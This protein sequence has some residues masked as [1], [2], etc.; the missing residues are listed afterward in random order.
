MRIILLTLL[1]A[2]CAFGQADYSSLLLLHNQAS[3]GGGSP[4]LPVSG[5]EVWIDAN[6]FT[7]L[8]DGDS[9]TS[10]T[11]YSGNNRH[12]G[13]ATA[14]SRPTYQTSEINGKPVI[15]FAGTDDYLT[16]FFTGNHGTIFA[17]VRP[18]AVGSFRS[19][20]GALSTTGGPFDAY[21]I[22]SSGT[23]SQPQFRVA[24]A[25]G[26][27]VATA[28]GGGGV[29]VNGTSLIWCVQISGST[30]VAQWVNG[31][32]EGTDTSPQAPIGSI[33]TT[34]IGATYYNDA[35]ADYFIGD[36][37]EF[38]IYPTALST[39]DK[40]TVGNYLETKWGVT[41]TDIP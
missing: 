40:N 27:S 23:D 34:I 32:A 39:A 2:V 26:G 33:T 10:A 22:G 4:S 31:T 1:S 20:S 9:I 19:W 36:I 21:I 16:N 35:V 7:A 6:Q 5:A 13:Q 12:M 18:S 3:G 28:E 29:L 14:G 37:G 38:I 30:S 24:V 41:W 25:T 15:R 17:V 8:N 11:D